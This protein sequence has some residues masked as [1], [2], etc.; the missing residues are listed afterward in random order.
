MKYKVV[1]KVYEQWLNSLF[2]SIECAYEYAQRKNGI[3]L[4]VKGE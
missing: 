1:Y 4:N 3:V 2:D